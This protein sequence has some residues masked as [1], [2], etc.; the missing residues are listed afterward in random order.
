[1]KTLNL[2]KAIDRYNGIMYDLCR[3]G[4]TIGP[5]G[6]STD[7]WNLRDMVAECDYVLSTYYEPGHVNYDMRFSEYPE[8]RDVKTWRSETGRLCRFINAYW[9]FAQ[10]LLCTEAHCSK[11]DNPNDIA[12]DKQILSEAL[13]R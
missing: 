7:A 5:D 10:A 3:E 2:E 13:R 1:M 8:D 12:F 6:V 4:Y 9:P 11:Y